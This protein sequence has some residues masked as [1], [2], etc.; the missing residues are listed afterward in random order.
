MLKLRGEKRGKR[1]EAS[2]GTKKP[3]ERD[4]WAMY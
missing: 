4:K 2:I 3:C 1:G